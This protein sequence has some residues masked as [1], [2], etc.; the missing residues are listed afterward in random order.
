MTEAL[1]MLGLA[2]TF[3]LWMSIPRDDDEPP[4]GTS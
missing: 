1:Q 2:A 4:T 3:L